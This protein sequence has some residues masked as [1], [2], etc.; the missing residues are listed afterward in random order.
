MP[1]ILIV[2]KVHP[3]LSETLKNDGY[4]C[5]TD[6]D[7]TYDD[8][9]ALP[10]NIDGLVIRSRFKVDQ[11]I[12]DSKPHLRFIIRIGSG[13]ENIDTQYA[14]SCGV[15]CFSTPEGN[16]P[17]V[18]EHCLALLLSALRHIP[19]ANNEVR[20]GEWL[21]EKNKGTELSSQRVGIIGYGHTGPAFARLLKAIGCQVLCYDRFKQRYADDNAQEASLDEIFETCSVISLHINYIPDNHYFINKNLINKAQQPFIF[22]NSSRGA[23]VN[24]FDVMDALDS[25]KI[26][27]ACLDVLEYES[28]Q[29]KIPQKAQWDEDLQRLARMDNVILTPHIGGQTIESER[30][31]AEL[32]VEIIRKFYQSAH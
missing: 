13:V 14:E 20:V 6:R 10:D 29:L 8:F 24:T 16:A 32:A 31:H 2:D 15:Q 28:T 26:S 3:I 17:A 27:F 23:A 12:I 9:I 4:H 22:I 19:N 1:T 5:R 21:R 25:G 11:A 30:R 7:I 18:A